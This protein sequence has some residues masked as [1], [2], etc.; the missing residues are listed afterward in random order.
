[1]SKEYSDSLNRKGALQPNL[2]KFCI[3]YLSIQYKAAE[4]VCNEILI[5]LLH[6]TIAKIS[7][8]IIVFLA[9]SKIRVRYDKGIVDFPS[10][11]LA[12]SLLKCNI[13]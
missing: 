13:H 1:M 4:Q 3:D 10:Q 2:K 7:I 11:K 5:C 8:L 9:A 6:Q 12:Y